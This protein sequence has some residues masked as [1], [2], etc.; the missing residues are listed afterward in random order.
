MLQRAS[1]GDA[2]SQFELG[3]HIASL[4]HE[5]ANFD[6]ARVWLRRA[7][8]QGHIAA[9]HSLDALDGVDS[10]QLYRANMT[11]CQVVHNLPLTRVEINRRVWTYIVAHGLRDQSRPLFA[12]ADDVL[13]AILLGKS[14]IDLGDL[15]TLLDFQTEPDRASLCTYPNRFLSAGGHVYLLVNSSMPGLVKIGYT[16][17]DP[18]RRAEELSVV[19]GVAVPFVVAFS[20]AVPNPA[21]LEEK[22][23]TVL[24]EFRISNNR[25]FFRVSV[26]RAIAAIEAEL[27]K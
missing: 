12:R 21:E 6:R 15:G 23:H 13:R 27:G 2:Q 5:E 20:V 14:E 3:D 10:G 24:E 9:Q 26:G 4:A 8:Q 19:T 18:H 1:A 22:I 11:L 17:R 16:D 7:A 25:E